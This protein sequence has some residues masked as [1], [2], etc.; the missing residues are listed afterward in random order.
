M[1]ARTVHGFAAL[2]KR[3][4]TR[5]WDAKEAE[6]VDWEGVFRAGMQVRCDTRDG[7]A[8]GVVVQRD[9]DVGDL[10]RDMLYGEGWVGD[11]EKAREG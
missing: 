2:L 8:M 3:A 4:Y 9:Q 5:A 7:G 6:A 11:V 10:R 1:T